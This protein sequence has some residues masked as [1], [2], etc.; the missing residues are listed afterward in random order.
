MPVVPARTI[1]GDFRS[2]ESH[3]HV[4]SVEPL[5]NAPPQSG[6]PLALLESVEPLTL[7]AAKRRFARPA[8]ERRADSRSPPQGG[9]PLAPDRSFAT[10]DRSK[11]AFLTQLAL[12]AESEKHPSPAIVNYV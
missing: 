6:D 9:A 12:A 10:F 1:F 4:A 7:P 8:R 2:L 3:I 11:G 5:N